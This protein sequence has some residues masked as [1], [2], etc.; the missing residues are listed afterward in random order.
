MQ[1]AGSTHDD[2][3]P[4]VMGMHRLQQ[5]G[6]KRAVGGDQQQH[7]S[8]TVVTSYNPEVTPYNMMR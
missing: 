7:A 4:K 6:A 2:G 3:Q 5:A 1:T 8:T